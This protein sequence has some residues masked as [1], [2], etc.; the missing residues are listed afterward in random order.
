[1]IYIKESLGNYDTVEVRVDGILDSQSVPI[2]KNVCE[3]HLNADKKVLLQLDGLTHISREGR[4][5]LRA[6]RNKVIMAN[7]PEFVRLETQD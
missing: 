2:L 3:V 7:I 6:I 4:D 1:M 5:F